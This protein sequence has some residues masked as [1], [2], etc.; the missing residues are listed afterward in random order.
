MSR[1]SG[2][3]GRACALLIVFSSAAYAQSAPSSA[4][5]KQAADELS[6]V[7]AALAKM[8]TIL[9]S[10][11]GKAAFNEFSSAPPGA[12][13]ATA[14]AAR[15]S[16]GSFLLALKKYRIALES[17][18]SQS[19]LCA[20]GDQVVRVTTEGPPSPS[21]QSN[22]DK[23]TSV[24]Q[25][26]PAKSA[27]TAPVTTPADICSDQS[28]LYLPQSCLP[29]TSA[30]F[31]PKARVATNVSRKAEFFDAMIS[32]VRRNGYRCDSISSVR[33]F[34]MSEGYTL[35]CNEFRYTYELADKGGR[36]IVTVK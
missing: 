18:V 9:D 3:L 27:T 10:E 32:L 20:M 17:F 8:E 19:S 4:R 29:T 34:I 2:L 6:K 30:P 7:T 14:E 21:S 31:E 16:Q 22:S 23:S 26:D 15:D 24:P 35:I 5:C 36:W 28:Q 25:N 1:L 11:K 12:L 13:R 33:P